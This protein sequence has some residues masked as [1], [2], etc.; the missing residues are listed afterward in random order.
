MGIL[1]RNT[2]ST[3]VAIEVPL[4]RPE[5]IARSATQRWLQ[6]PRTET[7]TQIP[8]SGA[9]ASGLRMVRGDHSREPQELGEF[10]PCDRPRGGIEK[11]RGRGAKKSTGALQILHFVLEVE[12]D[13]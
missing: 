10:G 11:V 4:M 13:R 3:G 9:V 6:H 1:R 12:R 8:E 5:C 7:H 2:I